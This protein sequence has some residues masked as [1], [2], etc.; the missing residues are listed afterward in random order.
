MEGFPYCIVVLLASTMYKSL[1]VDNSDITFWLYLIGWVW[2]IKML[3]G[4]L[5]DLTLTKRKWLLMMQSLLTVLLFALPLTL[6]MPSWFAISL[7]VLGVISFFS[8]TNDMSIDGFYLMALNRKHQA[9]FT[10]IRSAFWLAAMFFT[11]GLL[12]ILAGK[13]GER[14]G[15]VRGWQI[16]LLIGAVAFAVGLAV[17]LFL[18]PKPVRDAPAGKTSS[19]GSDV[20][21]TF[22][23]FFAQRGIVG[24]LL[25]ILFFRLSE[26]LLTPIINLFML[27]PRS[28]GGLGITVE[29]SGYINGFVKSAA[30]MG[31]QVLGGLAIAK[32]GLRRTLIP[33]MLTM[34]LPNLVYYWILTLPPDSALWMPAP[35]TADTPAGTMQ[36]SPSLLSI[37]IAVDQ[38]GYGLG[39]GAYVMF[40]LIISRNGPYP[41]AHYAIATGLM[42]FVV[43]FFGMFT[44]RVQEW[45]GYKGF[46]LL[47]LLVAIPGILAG[48]FADVDE[49]RR[50]RDAQQRHA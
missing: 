2:S 34:H 23:T 16:A 50:A 44:G 15:N 31:G 17:N 7:I 28:E 25:F 48:W 30:L 36:F 1:G 42:G 29:Q 46:F 4:P 3:W 49:E 14:F 32:W 35:I 33:F 38:F 8:A 5:V 26:V 40:L 11:T 47:V 39:M 24:I 22:V 9:G 43:A 37:L 13:F 6:G 20:A 45:L 19:A 41:T 12:V 27:D 10:G 21:A 18:L